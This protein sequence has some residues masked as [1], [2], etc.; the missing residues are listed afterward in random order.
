MKKYTPIVAAEST[1]PSELSTLLDQ[2]DEDYDYLVAGLEKLD[3][4][5]ASAS[6][7]GVEIAQ[8]ISDTIND[9]ISQIADILQGVTE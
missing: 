1:E 9:A 2:I 7:A 6:D 8:S 5:D 4:S 3:R